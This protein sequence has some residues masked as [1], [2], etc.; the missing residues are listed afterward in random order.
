MYKQL[1][2]AAVLVAA[3]I[4]PA[5]AAYLNG[6]GDVSVNYLHWSKGTQSAG[7]APY[8]KNFTYLELEGGANYTWGE[9]YGYVDWNNPTKAGDMMGTSLKGTIAVKTGLAQLRAYGQFFNTSSQG[10]TAQ[11]AVLGL[12]YPL[13]GQNWYF[14][15]Y[16]GVN[17]SVT[18]N[19][20]MGTKFS[21]LNGGAIGWTAGYNFAIGQQSFSLTNWSESFFSRSHKYIAASGDAN[22]INAN[23]ALALWWNITPHLTTGVQYRYSFANLGTV[24]NQNAVI[25]SLKYNF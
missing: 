19:E 9:L 10:F 21:G 17:D 18:T 14:V 7:R 11:H 3:S 23:G 1:S 16:I 4:A 6:F 8:Q 13:S 24:G 22:R 20:G 2:L 25:T 12:S 15:P 5:H